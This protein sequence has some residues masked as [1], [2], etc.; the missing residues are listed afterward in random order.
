MSEQM[1]GSLTISRP[2]GGSGP[3][4]IVIRLTDEISGTTFVEAR[5]ELADF[6]EALVGLAHVP[7]VFEGKFNYVGM[8][9][10]HKRINVPF[11]SVYTR[12]EAARE[13]LASE[14]FKAFEIDG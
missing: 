5:V 2:R 9:Y 10:E 3:D 6:A 1:K 14:A 12:D 11:E 4:R 7:C 8:R 13:R